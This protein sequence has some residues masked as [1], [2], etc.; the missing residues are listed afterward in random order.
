MHRPGGPPE[1]T[2]YVA[3]YTICP[4]VAHGIDAEVGSVEPGTL[5]DLALRDPRRPTSGRPPPS[6]G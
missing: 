3:E 2:R 6:L 4:A 1:A 5:A